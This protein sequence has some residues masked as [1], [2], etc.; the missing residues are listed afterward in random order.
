MTPL[1]AEE[2][3][4]NGDLHWQSAWG[5]EKYLTCIMKAYY[6]KESPSEKPR[7]RN[8]IHQ[9]R[10]KWQMM[11]QTRGYNVLNSLYYPMPVGSSMA[12]WSLQTVFSKER[13]ESRWEEKAALMSPIWQGG[14]LLMKASVPII[15]YSGERR[16]QYGNGNR[17]KQSGPEK[18][19]PYTPI[20]L[21]EV[22]SISNLDRE[23]KPPSHPLTKPPSLR[24]GGISGHLLRGEDKTWTCNVCEKGI[25]KASREKGRGRGQGQPWQQPSKY[26]SPNNSLLKRKRKN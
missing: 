9:R 11:T 20:H 2:K 7:E 16:Q 19:N 26:V 17:E 15:P 22:P 14:L 5:W 6:E 1:Q 8:D 4:K 12:Q 18:P 13:G 21:S 23:E 25:I 10:G 24:H 3:K